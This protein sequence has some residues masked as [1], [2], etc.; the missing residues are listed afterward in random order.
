MSGPSA[1][2]WLFLTAAGA[3]VF[4]VVSAATTA[5]L[6]GPAPNQKP[7][8]NGVTPPNNSGSSWT[9]AG[10]NDALQPTPDRLASNGPGRQHTHANAN[11]VLFAS[12]FNQGGNPNSPVNYEQSYAFQ[13]STKN[14]FAN[15]NNNTYAR[16]VNNATQD[17]TN[18]ATALV[19]G[20]GIAPNDD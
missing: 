13:T 3:V 10:G 20:P 5:Q 18:Q 4:T 6:Q 8:R 15:G 12:K 7:L 19:L 17:P 2:Q 14:P 1:L 11:G 16:A 9:N